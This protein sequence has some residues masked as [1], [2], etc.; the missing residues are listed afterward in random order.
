MRGCNCIA[1][2]I[3]REIEPM[4][5]AFKYKFAKSNLLP[6]SSKIN[7]NHA[8]MSSASYSL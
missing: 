1:K 6:N 5:V 8:N 3:E 2:N 7:F 4:I